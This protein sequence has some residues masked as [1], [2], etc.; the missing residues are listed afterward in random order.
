MQYL[1]KYYDRSDTESHGDVNKS[2]GKH[3]YVIQL[4]NLF[5]KRSEKPEAPAKNDAE[6]GKDDDDN[7]VQSESTVIIEDE[8][9]KKVSISNEK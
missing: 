3:K 6:Q 8:P 2:E 4:S 1:Q 7:A 5:K 9:Q